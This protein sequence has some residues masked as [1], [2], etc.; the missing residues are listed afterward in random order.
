M[1]NTKPIFMKIYHNRTKIV[2]TLG[3][4]SSSK[5]V[6]LKMIKAG[7]DI[8]RINFSHGK[9][10]DLAKLIKTIREINEKNNLHVGILADLQGPK[11]PCG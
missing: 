5:E 10:E 4:A 1:S 7:M 6:L 2:A 8:C 9:H 3:P 11:N